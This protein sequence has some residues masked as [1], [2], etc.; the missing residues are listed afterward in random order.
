MQ[1]TTVLDERHLALVANQLNKKGA[2]FALRSRSSLVAVCCE[3]AAACCED[4][5]TKRP[6]EKFQ[7]RKI[8][9]RLIPKNCRRPKSTAGMSPEFME[10]LKE[11]RSCV[12]RKK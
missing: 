3:I 10:L 4:L 5:G 9:D 11:V 12:K 6:I 8:L 2:W 7:A 1:V